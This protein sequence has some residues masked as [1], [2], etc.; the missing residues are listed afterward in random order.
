[1][2]KAVLGFALAL[3]VVACNLGPNTRV[4]SYTPFG[5]FQPG[6]SERV[7][8]E[9]TA[10]LLK[11][12]PDWKVTILNASLPPGMA[13]VNGNVVV[14]PNAPFELLGRF[15]LG[16]RLDDSAPTQSQLPDYLK[17]FARAANADTLV[18]EI[19]PRQDKP[20]KVEVVSGYALR[21]KTGATRDDEP[22]PAAIQFAKPADGDTKL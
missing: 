3:S 22:A 1:M 5:Q 10:S 7:S 6:E 20:D 12:A 18:V 19:E 14:S 13:V 21:L 16:F 4:N 15:E 17:R 8:H 11:P 2:K 9:Y